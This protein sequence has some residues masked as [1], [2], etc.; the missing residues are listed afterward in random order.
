MFYDWLKIEQE[1]DFELPLIADR[2]SHHIDV[3]TGEHVAT[4]QPAVTHEGSFSTTIQVQISGNRLRV[5]GNPSRINRIE[6]LFGFTRLSDCVATY[7]RILLDLGLPAL[8]PCTKILYR[9]GEDGTKVQRYSDGAVIQET[10]VT[11]N[12][13]VGQGNERHYIKALST[14]RYRNMI[15]NLFANGF[16][17]DWRSKK[18]NNSLIYPSVYCKANELRLHQMDKLK[19]KLGVNSEEY[20]YF[21]E[22]L[23]FCES[24]GVTRHEQK[25]KSAFLRRHD[26]RFYGLFDES[27]FQA[28]QEPFINLDEKLQVTAMDMENISERLLRL[29][30]VES[31]KAANTTA[32]YA[33]QWLHGQRF[34]LLKSQVKTHRA[35]LRHIGIDIAE[36]ADMSRHSPIFIRKAQ[37]IVVEPLQIPSWYRQADARPQLKAA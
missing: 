16:T 35:R 32:M 2:A 5:S 36:P 12:N 37:E 11:N 13:M 15:P 21:L 29:H 8:T 30:I 1:Y 19:R 34:D 10:H 24:N 14:L 31:T 9:T 28:I 23:N 7:N 33:L 22:V 25:L 26:L 18:G 3:E 17:C 4:T 20:Q 6:N 27:K